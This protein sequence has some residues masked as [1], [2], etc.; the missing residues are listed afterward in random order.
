[1]TH[2][3]PRST[4]NIYVFIALIAAAAVVIMIPALG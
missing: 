3:K 2:P 4:L 1:M